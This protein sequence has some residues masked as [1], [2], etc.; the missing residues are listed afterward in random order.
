MKLFSILTYTLGFAPA[1]TFANVN[2]LTIVKALPGKEDAAD[3]FLAS[4]IASFHEIRPVGQTALFGIKSF[5][6]KFLV[7]E[8]YTSDEAAL[9]WTYNATHVAACKPMA[10]LLDTSTVSVQSNAS[11]ETIQKFIQFLRPSSS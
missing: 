9:D 5:D 4:T 11:P 1:L 6:N 7:L 2:F 3:K 10:G 8:Q